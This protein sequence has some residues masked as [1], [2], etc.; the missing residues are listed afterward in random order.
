MKRF[1]IRIINILAVVA[2]IFI[3]NNIVSDRKSADEAVKKQNLMNQAE[4]ETKKSESSDEK[5]SSQSKTE[6]NDSDETQSFDIFKTQ[7]PKYTDGV[8]EGVGEGFGGK[9]KV[10]VT[11]ENDTIVNVEITS[12]LGED[13]AYLNTAKALINDKAFFQRAMGV[14]KNVLK[15]QSTEVDT[16]SGATYSS[17]G[18]IAAVKAAL[19]EAER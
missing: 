5:T 1:I 7:E 8:Y 18:I 2:I 17:K 13:P 12:A 10:N 4:F 11:I 14:V 9:I 3:Y 15:T 16:V 19:K 6:G